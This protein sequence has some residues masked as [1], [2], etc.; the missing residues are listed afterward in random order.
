MKHNILIL[1][2]SLSSCVSFLE[3]QIRIIDSDILPFYEMFIHEGIKRKKNYSSVHISI[4][5]S[6]NID[7]RGTNYHRIDGVVDILINKRLWDESSDNVREVVIMH[8][9]GHG[10]LGRNHKK[11][12]NS[13]MIK[14]ATCK[15]VAYTRN[16]K[17]ML[18]EL[19]R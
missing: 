15:Y 3:D 18:D 8:E 16:R 11:D 17:E 1:I 4:R 14:G 10:I 19:F 5:F 7:T 12:C 13:L 6:D 9:L 2:L